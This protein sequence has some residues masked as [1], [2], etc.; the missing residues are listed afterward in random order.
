MMTSGRYF[1]SK[2]ETTIWGFTGIEV[3]ITTLQ[4]GPGIEDNTSYQ[5]EKGNHVKLFSI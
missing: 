2:K 4:L 5:G 3:G 1:S